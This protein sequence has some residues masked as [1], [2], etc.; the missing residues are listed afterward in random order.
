M[1]F[2]QRMQAFFFVQLFTYFGN[3]L[4]PFLVSPV[5]FTRALTGKQSDFERLSTLS[6]IFNALLRSHGELKE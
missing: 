1:L 4:T 6:F 5:N 3:S 2:K